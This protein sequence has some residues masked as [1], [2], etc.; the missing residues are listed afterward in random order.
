MHYE[1]SKICSCAGLVF[2]KAR[3]KCSF[4]LYCI[5]EF[6]LVQLCTRLCASLNS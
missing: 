3:Y 5:E 2:V 1:C 6:E 4:V